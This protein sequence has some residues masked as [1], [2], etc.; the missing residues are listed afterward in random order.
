[1]P[2]R[3][4]EICPFC[5]ESGL[6]QKEKLDG[7]P[8]KMGALPCFCVNTQSINERFPLLYT[9]SDPMKEDI[10]NIGK[11][12]RLPSKKGVYRFKNCV[13]LG[14]EQKYLY[15]FKAICVGFY[16]YTD[17]FELLDGLQVVHNY[18]VEQIDDSHRTIYDLIDMDLF[19]LT[20]RNKTEN[21][22]VDK[23]VQ[24]TIQNRLRYNK[25]TW[26]FCE[27]M[28]NLENDKGCN[29]GTLEILNSGEFSICALSDP[30][31]FD[32]K[33]FFDAQDQRIKQAVDLN[34]MLGSF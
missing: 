4:Q 29:K 19:G 15:L 33:G 23:T 24:D 13:F 7:D 6:I 27:S 12:Y 1:M 8:I 31:V 9:V 22:A 3:D 5:A 2:Y 11:K 25:G 34:R 32:Y 20:F 17:K 16:N 21:K 26:V 14:N 18:H 10:Y 28:N 30:K